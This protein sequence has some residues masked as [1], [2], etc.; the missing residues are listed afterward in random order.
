VARVLSLEI[1]GHFA[2]MSFDPALLYDTEV[3]A[4]LTV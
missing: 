4:L 2:S 3:E 1:E